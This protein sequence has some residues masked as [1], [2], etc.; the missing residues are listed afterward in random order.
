[1]ETKKGSVFFFTSLLIL[2]LIMFYRLTHFFIVPIILSLAFTTLLYPLYESVLKRVKKKKNIASLITIL[3]LIILLLVPVYLIGDLLTRQVKHLYIT[4]EPFVRDFIRETEKLQIINFFH[5]ERLEFLKE[6]SIDFESF[7]KDFTQLV[8]NF[9]TSMINK[10]SQGTFQFFT[11][12]GI[13]LFCMFYF[14]RDGKPFANYLL[15]ICPMKEEH[16][17][18]LFEKFTQISRATIKGTLI[19]GLVQGGLG[20]LTLWIFGNDTWILWGLIMVLLSIIPFVGTWLILIPAGI[21]K[22]VMGNPF[23]G[24]SIILISIFIVSSVDNVLRP[25]LVGRD[26]KMHDL[27]IFFS[28]IGGIAVFGIA[29]FIIGPVFSALLVSLLDIYCSEYCSTSEGKG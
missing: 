28:T 6:Y 1:M 26:A 27:L 3:I 8:L 21:I 17:R 14:F 16:L 7:L 5:S 19:I 29:G 13:T 11:T 22:I 2:A 15:R 4:A 24:I 10:M 9:T 18:K 25:V 23:Q 20:A 12:F